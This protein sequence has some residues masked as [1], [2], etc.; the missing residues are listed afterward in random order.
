MNM[1][2]VESTFNNFLDMADSLDE[3][4]GAGIKLL[5]NGTSTTRQAVKNEVG[6]FMLSL[7]DGLNY[8]TYEQKHLLDLALEKG[9]EDAD[10][11]QVLQMADS[12]NAPYGGDNVSIN[13]FVL[14]DLISTKVTHEYT[15]S[16]ADSMVGLFRMMGQ[17]I[18][19]AGLDTTS[20]S[21]MRFDNY[22]SG[23]ETKALLARHD[24]E[25]IADKMVKAQEP[26]K[27]APAPKRAAPAAA[28][29]TGSTPK[30][31]TAASGSTKKSAGSTGGTSSKKK[32]AGGTGTP[33]KA[34]SNT[35]KNAG[36]Y[37]D[38]LSFELPD[39][40]EM[41]REKK[42]DGSESCSIVYGE[43]TDDNGNTA[44]EFKADIMDADVE[45][46]EE[47]TIPAGENPFDTI[48]RRDPERKYVTISDD[49]C[50][51]FEVKETPLNL[52]GRILKFYG[53]ILA[54]Q[55]GEKK[56]TLL[57]RIAAWDDDDKSKNFAA[58]EHI[59]E[60]K[61]ALRFNGKALPQTRI[62]AS[63]LMEQLTPDFEGKNTIKGSIGLQIKN[64]NDEVVSEST[65]V[66]DDDGH[67]HTIDNSHGPTKADGKYQDYEIRNGN[68]C[69]VAKNK[70]VIHIPE[71]VTAI[72]YGAFSGCKSLTEVTIP[73]TVREISSLAFSDCIKLKKITIPEG[74]KEIRHNTFS[75][76]SAL[77][78]ISIPES[79]EK[80]CSYAFMDCKKL[81]SIHIPDS[82]SEIENSA[83]WNCESLKEV[84]I[85]EG[86]TKIG[87][88]TFSG[89]KNLQ[90]VELHDGITAIGD[91][92]FM[93]CGKINSVSIPKGLTELGD[94]VFQDCTSLEFVELPDGITF[95]DEDMF[96]GCKKLKTVKLPAEI[97][98]IGDGA[99][100]ECESL[101]DISLPE[102]LETISGNAFQGCSKLK[103]LTIPKS[104]T[105]IG[106][107]AF[108]RCEALAEMVLPDNLDKI[109]DGL[110]R[111]CEKLK[112]VRFPKK[113]SEFG[114]Y[115]LNGCSSLTGAVLPEGFE[116]VD[117][118]MFFQNAKLSS[119]SLPKTLRKIGDNA[120]DG[121]T[122]LKEVKIPHCDELGTCVFGNCESLQEIELPEGLAAIPDYTFFKCSKLKK[123]SIP[124]SVENFGEYAFSDCAE[125]LSVQIPDTMTEIGDYTF[126]G[127]K[128][129]KEIQIPDGVTRIGDSAFSGCES[130]QE[131]CIPEG[132]EEIGDNAFDGCKLL[133]EVDLP[134]SIKS[135]GNFAFDDCDALRAVSAP[136]GDNIEIG[137][138]A[139]PEEAK[140][141]YRLAGGRTTTRKPGT[142]KSDAGKTTIQKQK[143]P[144]RNGRYTEVDPAEE[145][146]SHYG[147]LKREHD[148]FASM[149]IR[150]VSNNGREHE[151]IPLTGLMERQGKT[152]NAVYRRLKAIESKGSYD[153]KDTAL[154]MAQVFRVNESVFD[155]R[156]DDEGDIG[157]TML[158]KKS[159]FS[160]LRSFAWTL[161][162]LADRE[163]KS[164]D[165]YDADDLSEIC[166]FIEERQWLNYEEG[167]W[168]D[169]LCGH[170]DIHVYYMPQEMIDDGTADKICDIFNYNPIA[171]LD[172]FRNDLR[173][174]K[175]PMIRIHNELLKNRNREEKLDSPEAVV[176]KT[177]CALVMSAETSFFSEDGPMVFFH[178]YP[179][180]PTNTKPLPVG[181]KAAAPKKASPK[182]KKAE[183]SAVM[184][185][186][187]N[188]EIVKG[189]DG[190]ERI[191]FGEYPAGEPI[192]W[193]VLENN[194]RDLLLLSEYGLDVQP[195]DGG[196]SNEWKNSSLREWL[197]DDFYNE[198]FSEAEK[199]AILEDTHDTYKRSQSGDEETGS[200]NDNVFLLSA[201]ELKKYFPQERDM[202]CK[203]TQFAKDQGAEIEA[204]PMQ[205]HWWLRSPGVQLL[206]GLDQWAG[207]IMADG[208]AKGWGIYSRNVCARPVIRIGRDIL[209]TE[210]K[211]VMP[212]QKS[213]TGGAKKSKK[214][215]MTVEAKELISK[216]LEESHNEPYVPKEQYEVDSD[217]GALKLPEGLTRIESLQFNKRLV[218]SVT[219]PKSMKSIGDL[220]FSDCPKLKSVELNDGLEEIES[221]AFIECPLLKD[222]YLPDSIKK[223][224]KYAFSTS[225]ASYSSRITVHLSGKLAEY[226]VKHKDSTVKA[227]YVKAAEIDDEK[228]KDLEEYVTFQEKEREVN[229]RFE[230]AEAV[231]KQSEERVRAEQERKDAERSQAAALEQQKEA[232]RNEIWSR[233]RRLEEERDSLKGLF[234][235]FKRGK[236]DRQILEL[237][238]ELRRI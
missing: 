108:A 36:V 38:I 195:F 26:E 118:Y 41:I 109:S 233:I 191:R 16:A 144:R 17:A 135:I 9:F 187:Q 61:K 179:E 72:G 143:E 216:I 205:C 73:D 79:L 134:D 185:N 85:P 196:G 5:S 230:K 44:Y 201:R 234:A 14:H 151:A 22:M 197:N 154:T 153:L 114:D 74:V 166:S 183:A 60:I 167:S 81:K 34:G 186:A 19:A 177:W 207:C 45:D 133:C 193:L 202:I 80:I 229:E 156:H 86:V 138:W 203:A 51:E 90:K 169:G 152:D 175:N 49:P 149:G 83:F 87:D 37:N 231:R 164:I 146:Y 214:T 8:V 140:I 184:N 33:K 92:A 68:I 224:D 24:L 98:S 130:L 35:G 63:K 105:E 116:E 47:D 141:T 127:C 136:G 32:A 155:S 204:G 215:E 18:M 1:Y 40:Y 7:V 89:C 232:K 137:G 227:L 226:L 65:L 123:I 77:E 27:P 106:E 122:A 199:K 180:T 124:D 173:L 67:V 103:A 221:A 15:T 126:D 176:L 119:I 211:K 66:G 30:K 222:I 128:K 11:D 192:T 162:D 96:N 210:D 46:S 217:T 78:E 48:H 182:P 2:E 94:S 115:V 71:G 170:P 23:L 225:S 172:A 43:Y 228:Y 111:G 158:E 42:D 125:L 218:V 209:K 59:L 84:V 190:K 198:A 25:D 219:L 131:I 161:A 238:Q 163:G 160:A 12:I 157:V 76:C 159:Q 64:G 112:T 235:G 100:Y 69:E 10:S 88:Y 20:L 113:V 121:C 236:L 168:F 54:V 200:V 174:L 52:L 142:A 91:R 39:G 56:I 102:T 53:L 93:D 82:V 148:K 104:V 21:Q 13:A 110:L 29:K 212:E 55:T 213:K 57:S 107:Y 194:S 178:S 95:I 58:Y 139:F 31:T 50:A 189:P 120:F 99:F 237:K 129:L 132:V 188:Y 181:S 223:I 208:N 97:T 6:L 147:K 117:S 206:A 171:S 28:G 220:A 101:V 62:T 165:D 75:G 150:H 3:Q 4:E 145:L 70:R